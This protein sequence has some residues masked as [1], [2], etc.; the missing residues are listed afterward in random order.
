[1]IT[2]TEEEVEIVKAAL[3]FIDDSPVGFETLEG[4]TSLSGEELWDKAKELKKRLSDVTS[5]I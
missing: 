2:L 3:E 5:N 4:Y 1:M